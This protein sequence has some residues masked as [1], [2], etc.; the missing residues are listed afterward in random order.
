MKTLTTGACRVE[1]YTRCASDPTNAR[2][3]PT[4]LLQAYGFANLC[5][6]VTGAVAM[7]S[8]LCEALSSTKTVDKYK[9]FLTN[10]ESIRNIETNKELVWLLNYIVHSCKIRIHLVLKRDITKLPSKC[11]WIRNK[12]WIVL[13]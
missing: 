4:V 8:W 13:L 12:H 10:D 3:A 2:P 11:S 7:A 5:L 1:N 9:N 6:K